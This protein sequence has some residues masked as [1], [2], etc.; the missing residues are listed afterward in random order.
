[1]TDVELR[2]SILGTRVRRTEDPTLLTGSAKYLDDLDLPG[3]LQAVFARSELAHARVGAVHID[4]ARAVPGVVAVYTAGDLG[5]APHH[6]FATVHPDFARPPLADGVVRFVGEAI[7]VVVGETVSAAADGAAA[8]WADYDPLPVLTD[9]ELALADTDTIIF[10][11]HGSNQAIIDTAAE[12]VELDGDDAA[13]V[14]RGRY[15]NQ[16]VAVVPMEPNGCAAVP[17]D[18]G[19][20]TFYASTQMPHALR[21]PAAPRTRARAGLGARHRAAGR[22]WLRRQGRHLRRV[23]GGRRRRPACSVG[24]SRGIRRAATTWCRCPTA[25]ARSSTPS[26]APDPTARSPGCACAWSATPAPTR[27]SAPS[28]R[29]ARS[30]CPTAPTGSRRSSSTWPSPSRTRPRWAPTAAPG[31]RRRRRC[32]SASSTTPPTSSTSTRSSCGKRNFLADD[33]FP[34]RTLTGV[35]YDTGA[36]HTPLDAAAEAIGYE[37]L[38]AEQAARRERGDRV[39]LGIG[40]ASYVEI[41]AGGGASEFGGVEVHDDG[42]ATVRAGTFSHGQGHQTAFAMIVS[43]QTGIPV[44]HIRLVDGDTALVPKG[45]GTGGSR[46]LQLGGSA[47][48]QATEALVE[49][50]RRLAAHLLEADAA[51]IVVD[52]DA[53]TVGVAGVP[54]RALS[55]A[56]LAARAAEARRRPRRR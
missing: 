4:E 23:L 13:V 49:K 44:E 54:A 25:A 22:R 21:R 36:Y 18:D 52:R 9:P 28:C 10:P 7:A 45:G 1:M 2:G 16:R 53:G 56:E 40:V 29:R 8:V 30:G 12:P 38:R 32:W 15:V 41:T 17:G 19:M 33:V 55:W 43:D 11:D 42:S 34:F 50:A 51:D 39:A 48:H 27:R 6:G 26:S 3:K 37:E 35:T 31:G 46:S 24:P 5:V 20:L 14:V 47:V